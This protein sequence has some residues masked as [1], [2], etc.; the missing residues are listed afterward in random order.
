ML[1]R[2]EIRGGLSELH[3]GAALV[4]P[5]PAAFDRDVEASILVAG[6]WSVP[7]ITVDFRPWR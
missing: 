5:Q 6:G 4:E 3:I 2:G 1:S 7:R